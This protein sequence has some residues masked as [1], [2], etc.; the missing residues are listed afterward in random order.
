MTITVPEVSLIQGVSLMR[1][2]GYALERARD[3]GEISFARRLSGIPFPRFH[4]YTEES[5]R[6]LVIKLH[7]DQKAPTYQ[8]SSAHAG[9]Y[10]GETL[11]HEIERI[12]DVIGKGGWEQ[13]PDIE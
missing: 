8:G 7:L 6:G 1:R 2:A 13:T 10:D 5:N 9:E 4:A 3:T 12:N 11:K